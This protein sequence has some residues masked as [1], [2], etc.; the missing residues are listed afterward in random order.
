MGD[1]A[2]GIRQHDPA[3]T[4]GGHYRANAMRC[5]G[6]RGCCGNALQIVKLRVNGKLQFGQIGGQDVNVRIG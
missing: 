4:Q 5:G 1:C 2:L 3:G 6:I